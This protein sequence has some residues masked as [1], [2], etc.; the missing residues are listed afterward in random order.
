MQGVL[1]L[2]GF[3]KTSGDDVQLRGNCPLPDCGEPKCFSV[4]VA[5][6]KWQCHRCKVSGGVLDLYQKTHNVNVY[7]AAKQVC[8]QL[9]LP[10]PLLGHR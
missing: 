4:N 1:E 5:K 10:L 3:R 6:K 2:V 7:A 9:G 8:E